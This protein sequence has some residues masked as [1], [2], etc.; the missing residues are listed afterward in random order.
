VTR[1][2]LRFV[3]GVAP[4]GVRA[5]LA[6]IVGLAGTGNAGKKMTTPFTGGQK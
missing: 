3:G 2:G 1:G 6:R 5:A 4:I